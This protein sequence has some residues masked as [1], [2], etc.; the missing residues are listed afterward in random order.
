[1]K[2]AI[3]GSGSIARRHYSNIK[4]IK[5]SSE[6]LIYTRPLNIQSKKKLFG[7]DVNFVSEL[8]EVIKFSP[9]IAVICSPASFH[10]EQSLRLSEENIN[11]FIEK[12]LSN[13]VSGIETLLMK[14]KK[15]KTI[16][17]I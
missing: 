16:K 6:I 15:N 12:P 8:D 2:I 13:K 14:T 11:L 17:E 5:P 10:I 7:D 4:K 1:M 9:L 3:I